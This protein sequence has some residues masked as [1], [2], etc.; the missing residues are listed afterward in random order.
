MLAARYCGRLTGM[1]IDFFASGMSCGGVIAP[2][3]LGVGGEVRVNWLTGGVDV[4][5]HRPL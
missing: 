5:P 1:T 3:H 4:V 2:A